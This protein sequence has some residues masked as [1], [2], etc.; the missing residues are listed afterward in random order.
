MI[1]VTSLPVAV[2]AAVLIGAVLAEAAVLYVGYGAL[3]RALGPSV[4]RAVGGE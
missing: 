2:R 1:D 3:T 4:K